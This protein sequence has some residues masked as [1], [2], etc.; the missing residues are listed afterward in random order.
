MLALPTGRKRAGS[1]VLAELPCGACEFEA[2]FTDD[3]PWTPTSP[4]RLL[5]L[6]C[7]LRRDHR[8]S[9]WGARPKGCFHATGGIC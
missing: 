1:I 9:A 3:L 8:A 7:D 2:Q 5:G 4:Q 6:S